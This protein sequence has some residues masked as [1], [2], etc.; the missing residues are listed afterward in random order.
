[1]DT[2]KINSKKTLMVAHRGVSGIECENTAAAFVAAV[3][4]PTARMQ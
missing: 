4:S 1:M 2:I 3:R